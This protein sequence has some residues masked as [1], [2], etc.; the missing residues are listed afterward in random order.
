MVS[1]GLGDPKDNE[2]NRPGTSHYMTDKVAS[3]AS[4][5]TATKSSQERDRIGG[6]SYIVNDP[7]DAVW[8]NEREIPFSKRY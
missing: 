8:K 2:L 7:R 1:G 5:S 6:D 4:G 3:G